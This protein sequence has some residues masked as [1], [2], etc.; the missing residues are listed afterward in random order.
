M[1]ADFLVRQ[2]QLTGVTVRLQDASWYAKYV[3]PF[4]DTAWKVRFLLFDVLGDVPR[5]WQASATLEGK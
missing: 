4:F 2:R 5:M 3:L 1:I